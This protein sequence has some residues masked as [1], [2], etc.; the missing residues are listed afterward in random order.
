M[1]ATPR[2]PFFWLPVFFDGHHHPGWGSRHREGPPLDVSQQ[3]PSPPLG[4]RPYRPV[5]REGAE[6]NA[7]VLARLRVR[8]LRSGQAKETDARL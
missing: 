1:P 2:Q 4:L 5:V 7:A 8:V 3:S 6:I